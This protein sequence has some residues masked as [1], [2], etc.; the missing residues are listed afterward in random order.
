[1]AAMSPDALADPITVVVDLVAGYEHALDR[2]A[3]G[4]AVTGMAGGRTKQ[5]RL[6]QALVDRPTLLIEG[7]SP[8]PRA[9]GDL[10]LA[11][12]TAGAGGI[13]P[14]WCAGCG[15]E[16]TSMQRRGGDWYCS[17]CFGRLEACAGCGQQRH[18]TFRDRQGRPRCSQCPDHDERDPRRVLVEVITRLNPGLSTNTITSAIAATVVKPAHEH[19]LAWAIEQTPGLL[20]GDGAKAPFPMVL[21][22]IDAL[23]AAGA[24]GIQRP[25]CPRCARIVVLSKLRDGLRICRNCA[26]KA[27]AVPCNR[28]AAVREPA[29]R[30]D[31]GKP[32][33]PNCLVSDPS[34]LEECVGC[35]RRQRV[36]TRTPHGPLCA[37]CIPRRTA[38]CSVCGRTT[39]CTVSK[40]TGQP[41]CGA[42]ARTRAQCSRCGQ[43]ATIRAGTREAS[44]CAGCAVP[45]PGFWKTCPSCGTS[46]RLIAGPCSR[47]RLHQRLG[48]LLTDNGE[49]RP[50]L[51]VL[52]HTLATAERPAIVLNWLK[53][54]TVCSVL[55][56]LAAGQR[57]L[58]HAALDDLPPG[59]PVE[60]LR[61]VLVATNAL[62]VRDE[63]L[64]RI[65]RW[66]THTVNERSDPKDKELLHRYA[67][68][69]L[70]R[71]L[72]QRNGD[73]PATYGQL[74]TVRQRLR[75]AIGLLDWLHARDLTLA[76][77]R[78]ADLDTWITSSDAGPRFGVGP[79]VRWAI[80]QN[81]NRNLRFAA[82][83]WTG[84][85][86]PLDHEKRWH[87]A[88]RLLHDNTIDTDDRVA[89][90]LLL[91]YAQRPAAISRL[92]LED[93]TA[94]DTTTAICFGTVPIT[95]P[96]PLA[97]L[98]RT[99]VATRRGHAVLGDRGTS[100]WLFPG[101]Q[102]SRPISADRLG[103][104]LRQ[105][106][107]RPAQT[108]STALFQLATELPAAVLA[109][110]LG[111]HIKVAVAW[112]HVSAG[113]WTNYAADVSR[114][115]P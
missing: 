81:I 64:A 46:G 45:D 37:S 17:P 83:R 6:A 115:M 114:R 24:T 32:L 101:G 23:C 39:P 93:I 3:I 106:G 65:Q 67:V 18:V 62:H 104:R 56:E 29:A 107:L 44:L 53:H 109:R 66:V 103:Q 1:M 51:A 27:N 61:S 5:R 31:Q 92:T 71:R 112:Q 13:S 90:L 22:L 74:D 35:R 110:M 100:P 55:A 59:K 16:I 73:T 40:T 78:Q 28:C 77:C 15:R 91:L 76:T 48:Q 80:A 26:A 105:L 99:L 2:E 25:A 57:P 10:L 69:H 95:L 49:T 94:T 96:E 82:T 75:A 4:A 9:V 88:K 8:A 42:C 33:C 21:R 89:G 113:D 60:H 108:R 58:S 38:I 50:E 79:F 102:P 72:R 63:H 84:P 85:A 97:S 14:P 19:K 86:Q 43:R 20:T 30:D 70:L 47:C 7:R 41:W 98:T 34:N 12:R 87:Q 68:W 36:N 52:H 111:I 54:P 11:L